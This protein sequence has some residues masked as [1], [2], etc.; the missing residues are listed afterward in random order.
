EIQH[1]RSTSDPITGYKHRLLDA[2]VVAEE[3]LKA[4]DKEAKRVIDEALAIAK[5]IPEPD[6]AQLWD[7]VYVRG[8]E[9]PYLRGRVVEETHYYN[10][11]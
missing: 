4:I 1:M 10:K 6:A 2:G 5:A 11:Q 3:D 8:S 9:V 7:D